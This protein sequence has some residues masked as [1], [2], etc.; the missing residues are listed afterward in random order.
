MG[1]HAYGPARSPA[2]ML[3]EYRAESKR[4]RLA[5]GWDW[6]PRIS[7]ATTG[8][9]GDPMLYELGYGRMAADQH[10]LC[11][12]KHRFVSTPRRS[13]SRAEAY[14]RL[15]GVRRLFYYREALAP[16]DRRLLDKQLVKARHRDVR[17]FERDVVQN[18]PRDQASI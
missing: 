8:P 3:V 18:C 5:P 2:Q 11:S 9:D 10:W 1:G 13:A 12:W 6:P 14:E 15:L 4:L 17:G 16:L 7:I